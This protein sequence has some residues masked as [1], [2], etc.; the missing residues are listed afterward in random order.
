VLRIF[1]NALNGANL[2][3]LRRIEVPNAL[4]AFHRV[5]DVILDALGDGLVGA[6]RFADIAV[7]ALLGNLERQ[8]VT[9]TA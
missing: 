1:R 7:D 9:P 3:T 5:D 2:D 6:L 8:A 4:G